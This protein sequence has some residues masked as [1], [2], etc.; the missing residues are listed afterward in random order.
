MIESGT[1]LLV[2][3]VGVVILGLFV[4]I[5]TQSIVSVLVVGVL[6]YILYQVLLK[7]GYLKV[8]MKDG[9]L[10]IGLFEKAPAPAPSVPVMTA[11]NIQKPE[12]FYVVVII[13]LMMKL[14]LYVLHTI[15]N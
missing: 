3:I 8:D 6:G 5:S 7:L 12:V 1:M 9:G 4:F 10:D 14:L 13:I 2:G 11:K 15:Q